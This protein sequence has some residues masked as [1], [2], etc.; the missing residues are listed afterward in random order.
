MPDEYDDLPPL[1]E[2]VRQRDE[3][4]ARLLVGRL[5]PLV[6]QADVLA[7]QYDAV[8]ANPPY[9]GSKSFEPI[10]KSWLRLD[11]GGY[12]RD[13]FSAFILR[14]LAL[15]KQGGHSGVMTSFVWMFIESFKQLRGRIFS[16]HTIGSLV[17]LHYDA[18]SGAKAH[19]CT[20]TLRKRIFQDY[21]SA[22]V[23]LA[24]FPGVDV[25]GPRTLEAIKNRHCGWFF[26]ASQ[27]DF[28]KI[29]GS[30]LAYWASSGLLHAFLEGTPIGDIVDL[31]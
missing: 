8:V 17:Q 22:F 21:R 26:E 18:F 11:Y 6:R 19:V 23:R 31:K 4:A 5:G 2:A 9:M 7:R 29:P 27:R 16:D 12:D 15:T 14:I 30:P 28:N 1:L 10:L 13:L 25:Q 3:R 24:E 20:F